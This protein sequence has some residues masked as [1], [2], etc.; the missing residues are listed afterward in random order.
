MQ[1][2]VDP[3]NG[4]WQDLDERRRVKIFEEYSYGFLRTKSQPELAH[5][6]HRVPL[7]HPEPEQAGQGAQSSMPSA[8]IVVPKHRSSLTR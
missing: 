6:S 5:W 3:E 4:A 2:K 7:I 1:Q 8:L